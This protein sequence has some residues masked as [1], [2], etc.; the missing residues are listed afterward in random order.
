ML[1]FKLFLLICFLP[2][3]LLAQAVDDQLVGEWHFT[4]QYTLP[5]NAEN[6]PGPF[7]P[8]PTTAYK[9]VD[10]QAYPFIFHGE[11]PSERII[12]FIPA[13]S[14]PQQAF[15]LELWL[16]DHVN[17]PVGALITLKGREINTEPDWLLGYYEDDVIFTLVTEDAPSGT[18]LHAKADKAWKRYWHH[19]VA[20]YDGSR[21]AMYLNGELLSSTPVDKRLAGRLSSPEI[22]IA[23]YMQNE[24]YMDLGNLVR[25]LRIY[26]CALNPEQIQSHYQKWQ[27]TVDKGLL[28]LDLFHFTAGPYLHYATQ[29]SINL[30]WETDRPTKALIKYGT[31]LPLDQEV[32]I[33]EAKHIQEITLKNLEPATSYFYNIISTD[34]QGEQIESGVLTFQTAVQEDQAYAF[35]LIGDTEARPH[36]NDRI[37]KMVWD[38]RPNFVLNLGDLTDGGF[39]PHKFEWNYEYFAGTRQL[40]SRIPVFPVP[41]N[42]E[43]DLFWYKKYHKLPGNEAYYSFRYGNA[44]FFMLNSNESKE[45]FKPGGEQYVWLEKAL[46]ASA[47]KWKFVAHHH[48]PYSADE[49]DYGN[50]W[51]GPSSYGDPSVRPIVPLY[52]KYGV[53]MVFFGH[54]H[55]YQRSLP[56]LDN[57]VK[58]KSGVI[59]VQC[60]GGGGNLEDFAPA[61]A[62]FSAKT[63]RGHHYATIS[64]YGNKLR[65]QVFDS[66]GR[67]KDFLDIE[68]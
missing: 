18:L 29:N 12:N 47:A 30:V 57:L 36:I 5:A 3:L 49:N 27:D 40:H 42:G 11:E 61:R 63:Y 62:W 24:P 31:Q 66:E 37:T 44:E 67:M 9:A 65:Y 56:V 68:K 38:E 39:E 64:V 22:E 41:G 23:A 14:L 43:A 21:M 15:T 2:I 58:E 45:Q 4:P 46:Q 7:I 33:K 8:L 6:I 13:D 53:D 34:E 60:G 25:S 26:D 50:S 51:E 28:Y 48:A 20:T 16:L 10:T 32:E 59:Y 17:Q 52:E 35:A 1:N 55:T 54:L 19:L